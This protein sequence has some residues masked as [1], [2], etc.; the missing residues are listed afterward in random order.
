[1]SSPLDRTFTDSDLVQFGGGRVLELSG[2]IPGSI[3]VIDSDGYAVMA[4]QIEMLSAGNVCEGVRVVM[5]PFL[6]N[7][8]LAGT[9][10]IRY[11]RGA[12]GNDSLSGEVSS[13][14]T[15][16]ETMVYSLLFG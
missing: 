10:K 7:G 14:V 12:K 6:E 4:D 3:T 2:T 11:N 9:W 8:V 1:M 16:E 5:T 13:S 15:L